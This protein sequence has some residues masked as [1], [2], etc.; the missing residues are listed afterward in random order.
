M[1]TDTPVK[2]DNVARMAR[3]LIAVLTNDLEPLG[4]ADRYLR[5]LH[6][7]PYMPETADAEYRL[8]A[9]RSTM[10]WMPL[11]V[12]TPVQAMYVDGYQPGNVD[13]VVDHNFAW[14]HWQRSRLDAKRGFCS[15]RG[16]GA[17]G[18]SA[19]WAKRSA[20]WGSA[21]SSSV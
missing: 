14:E 3:Q 13:G 10:N 11:I 21:A 2:I 18:V 19:S 16:N 9:E 15:G 17:P 8:L 6:D 12:E 4:V 1:T 7:L 20:I 5:N